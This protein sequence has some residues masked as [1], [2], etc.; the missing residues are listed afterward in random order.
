MYTTNRNGGFNMDMKKFAWDV[1]KN[2]GNIEAF[3]LDQDLKR[4]KDVPD[5]ILERKLVYKKGYFAPFFS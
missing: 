1:C 3:L 4:Q 5:T 2:A